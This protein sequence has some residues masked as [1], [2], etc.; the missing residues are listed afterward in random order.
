[1]VELFVHMGIRI[2]DQLSRMGGGGGGGVE[3]LKCFMSLLM[4]LWGKQEGA[5]YVSVG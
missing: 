5:I 3:N 1:M 4:Q 2:L